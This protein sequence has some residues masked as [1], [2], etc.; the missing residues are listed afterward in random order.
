V[1]LAVIGPVKSTDFVTVTARIFTVAL[2]ESPPP[3]AVLISGPEQ[4]HGTDEVKVAVTPV[5]QELNV[6]TFQVSELPVK[7]WGGVVG[8]TQ[9]TVPAQ[10]GNVSVTVMVS[11]GRLEI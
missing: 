3:T 6:P 10:V 7:V 8:P 4:L 11:L 1:L 2:A 5:E 9:D